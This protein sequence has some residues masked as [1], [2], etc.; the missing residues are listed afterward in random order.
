MSLY[1]STQLE[2]NIVSGHIQMVM[3]DGKQLP[4]YWA[5][6]TT[7]S[8]YPAIALIHDWWGLTPI[9]R[10]Y[11]HQFAQAGYYVIAPDLFDGKLAHTPV[12]AMAL[13]QA[14]GDG[15]YLRVDTALRVLERH[16]QTTAEVAA[17]GIG[18]GGSLALEAAI[19]RTDLEAAVCC[20]GFPQRYL[21]RF[22]SVKAPVLA[23]YGTHEPHIKPK[24]VKR[25][26][27]ELQSSPLHDK[28]ELLLIQGAGHDFMRENPTAEQR[29]F[30]QQAWQHT[31]AF[32][33]KHM[34]RPR[35]AEKP[36][37]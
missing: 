8:N 12:E 27:E 24:V 1:D 20:Y 19:V 29:T 2:Y 13:I 10:Y 30:A 25:M 31:M 15:G 11:V 18:M 5:H 21:G 16:H 9:M 14:L 37:M 33:H 34:S 4:A 7:G 36:V 26:E 3:D 28:H 35:R 32:L 6:P 22:Q 23:I 17:V